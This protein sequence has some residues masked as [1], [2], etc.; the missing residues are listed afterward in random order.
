MT[1][2]TLVLRSLVYFRAAHA[3]LLAGMMLVTAVLTGALLLGD[4]VHD[5]LQ[6]LS[7]R[8]SGGFER[9]VT[10][11][12]FFS[13]S[14]AQRLS[15][16][17]LACEPALLV[18][19]RVR[20][21]RTATSTSA[22]LAAMATKRVPAGRAWI[23]RNVADA[24]NVRP[25]D[26][27][28]VTLAQLRSTRD[29]VLARRDRSTLN[30]LR[31]TVE[32]ILDE[33]D[34]ASTDTVL[35]WFDL[36]PS[37]R[38]PRNVW[39]NLKDLQESLQAGIPRDD[40]V[41]PSPANVL[42]TAGARN[43]GEALSLASLAPAMTL[44]DYGLGLQTAGDSAV[45]RSA[46]LYIPPPVAQALHFPDRPTT[47][48]Y[49]LL[50]DRV[51]TVRGETESLSYV[52]AVGVGGH[53]DL[54]LGDNEVAVNQWTADQLR[55]KVGDTLRVD[56]Y[57]L[58]GDA[59][60]VKESVA[61]K[62]A[63]IL[64]MTGLGADPSLTPRFAGLTD[65]ETV[66]Q[67]DPPAGFPF[68]HGR[69]TTADEAYWDRHRAAPKVFFALPVA[70]R[71]DKPGPDRGLTSIRVPATLADTMERDALARLTPDRAGFAVRPFVPVAA[72]STDFASLF[73]GL[74]GLLIIAALLLAVLLFRLAVEQRLRQLGLLGALGY[75]PNR[76]MRLLLSEGAMVAL[77]GTLAGLPVA[78]VYSSLLVHGLGSWWIGATGTHVLALHVQPATLAIGGAI[79]LV[80]ALLALGWTA[81]R[82]AR[83]MPVGPLRDTLPE[84]SP[85][86]ALRSFAIPIGVFLVA[87]VP[88][89]LVMFELLAKPVGFLLS[90][91]LL[92]TSATLAMTCIPD[93]WRTQRP[94]PVGLATAGIF[95][96][97]THALLCLA[98]M[99][100]ATFLLTSVTAFE[101][102]PDASTPPPSPTG[103]YQLIVST[104]I[105]L[106]TDLSTPA[107]RKLLGLPDDPVLRAA[108]FTPLRVHHGDD[109]SCLNMTRPTSAT[110]IGVPPRVLE[111]LA[112]TRRQ[113]L[114][115]SGQIAAAIDADSAEYILHT[116]LGATLPVTGTQQPVVVERL[117]TRS[118]F[119]NAGLISD[120][121]FE[122]LF[123]EVKRSSM[124]LVDCPPDEVPVLRALLQHHLDD[125]GVTVE[126]MTERLE[127]YRA[128]ASSY[129]AAFQ[130]LGALAILVGALGEVVVLVRTVIQRRSELAVLLAIGFTYGRVVRLLVIEHVILLTAGTLV[131][132]LTACVAVLPQIHQ[133]RAAPVLAALATILI[134]GM[135]VLS[136]AAF[137]AMR[138]LSTASLRQE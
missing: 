102:A 89:S 83:A 137:L 131:G 113:P 10:A 58:E 134:V 5:S 98:L 75:P 57:R 30:S 111:R 63:K 51:S 129:I 84:R 41:T 79:S 76:I 92:L 67:W 59:V 25:G 33:R 96:K 9:V 48:I 104:Q 50:L 52:M 116:S 115:S 24:L 133:A 14:L 13:D 18:P 135:L 74:S 101:S 19:G 16:S 36:H 3:A 45:L 126:T 54:G 31:V 132:V 117:L 37:Q 73:L 4:S 138:G 94:T 119:Q 105:P 123:P 11:P 64:P 46:T 34:M 108:E 71:L 66:A 93:G 118:P 136:L 120:T 112:A 53:A 15:E 86:R 43:A 22:Q 121:D 128:V 17:G 87:L 38:A 122:R 78:V 81:H 35:A 110:L 109:L 1:S 88:V 8:R 12:G 29:V 62:V 49:S 99:A 26:A 72:P 91:I 130:F 69:V 70:Q 40:R 127:G 125:F 85:R 100:V 23:T 56:P 97:R 77:L 61:F 47:E 95:R 42:L 2:L 107:G 124:V 20:A 103:G 27:L 28:L 32:H 6:E 106:T 39:L 60:V 55:L 21:E 114:Q 82:L 7:V 44:A 65:A 80:A 90:G 68:D